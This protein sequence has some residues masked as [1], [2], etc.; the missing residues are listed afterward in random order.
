MVNEKLAKSCHV[1]EYHKTT[2]SAMPAPIDPRIL[3]LAEK[4]IENSPNSRASKVLRALLKKGKIST[5]ELKHLG[6]DHPPRAAADVKDAGIPLVTKMVRNEAGRRMGVYVFGD[7]D[8]IQGGMVGGRAAFPKQFK[9]DLIDKYGS[10]DCITGATLEPRV[11]Q[12]DHRIPYRISGDVPLTVQNYML[13][14][15]SSQRA[16]SWSCEHCP[17]MALKD[18]DVCRAC[19]WAFPEN[20]SHIATEELRR[21]DVSW[22]GSDVAA[23]DRL[24]ADADKQGKSV[25]ELIRK[26]ARQRA[27][28]S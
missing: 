1:R 19:F 28:D 3:A 13:L 17:N 6:Y 22:Q 11:L 14:D 5:G 12:I 4:V 27:K 16:K 9:K 20:Y 25:A 8:Q 24:K 26:W 21:V 15:G 2:K 18:P 23:Y 10:I 7:P